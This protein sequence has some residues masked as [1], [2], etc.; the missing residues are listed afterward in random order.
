[1]KPILMF[2]YDGVIANSFN[3]VKSL[4]N[5]ICEKYGFPKLSEDGLKDLFDGNFAEELAKLAPSKENMD[6]LI[7]EF[8]GEYAKVD[9]ELFSGIKEMFDEVY[10]DSSYIISSAHSAVIE[11]N[12]KRHGITINNVLGIDKGQSKVEKFN[13]IKQNSP[14]DSTLI[15]VGDTKGDIIESHEAGILIIATTWGYH[16]RERLETLNPDY[17]ANSPKELV[18]LVKN[19]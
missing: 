2:D 7:K 16:N 12:L 14:E 5:N 4:Y 17:V 18:T 19:F 3:P 8:F 1:M 9:V 6:G 10:S 11:A 15:Y 13:L